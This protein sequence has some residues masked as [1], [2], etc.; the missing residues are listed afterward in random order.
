MSASHYLM[1]AI[2][3]AGAGTFSAGNWLV[4]AQSSEAAYVFETAPVTEGEIRRVVAT[5]GTV[6]PRVTVQV[7]SELSGRI[8]T[9][10]ADFNTKVEAG[11]LLAVID[12]KTFESKAR[13]TKADV[14]SA[15]A[16]VASSEAALRKAESV[17]E[18]AEKTLARQ[19]LLDKKGL[20]PTTSVET[21]E[22][23]VNVARAEVDV[24]AAN[25]KDAKALLAQKVAQQEQ[26]AIDLERTQI[27]APIGG[28]VLH[29]AVDV[30]QTVAASFQA[31]ELFRLAGD[32]SS[33]HIEAQV[34]ESDIGAI[35]PGQTVTFDVDAYQKRK[36]EGRIEQ[37]RMSPAATD[38]VVT[39]TVI[40]NA[41]NGDLSLYPGMTANVLIETGRRDNVVRVPAEA[42]H[43][44]PPK[45]FRSTAKDAPDIEAT[46]SLWTKRLDLDA[47]QVA[48]LTE[49][50]RAQAT[51]ATGEPRKDRQSK[52]KSDSVDTLLEGLLTPNQM[53]RL[54]S[55]RQKRLETE[56]ASV[57]VLDKAGV[58][59]KR[60]IR[61]G[62]ADLSYVELASKNLKPGDNLIVR[63]R[64]ERTP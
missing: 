44:K 27:R 4:G 63:S 2:V 9:I 49:R 46:V 13:Q 10:V 64:K 32:L 41:E 29:R 50:I 26:A 48:S 37:I 54:A 34:S 35:K 62:L 31:P 5:T 42:I 53:A 45:E 15:E 17:L 55:L 52:V 6:R 24:A 36:F 57:W 14:L 19:Q 18:N 47:A 43:Y 56:K 23:D 28:I 60:S 58:P 20:S 3:L 39:Y 51:G 21:A 30:G 1:V 12:P 22:R 25:I 38:S 59:E 61:I 8:K 11:D 7:G 33:I 16:H 40:V